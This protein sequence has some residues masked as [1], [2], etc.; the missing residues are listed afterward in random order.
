MN[1]KIGTNHWGERHRLVPVLD[2]QRE[3]LDSSRIQ[4]LISRCFFIQ[5]NSGRC[6]DAATF[7]K[8]TQV[9][10]LRQV[11]RTTY[12]VIITHTAGVTCLAYEVCKPI[13]CIPY[14]NVDKQSAYIIYVGKN[15]WKKN[16]SCC[17]LLWLSPRE[18]RMGTSK[19]RRFTNQQAFGRK[20]RMQHEVMV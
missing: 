5:S 16:F 15:R 17:V 4:R 19:R 14:V 2:A 20:S 9:M 18:C 12:E 13:L 8:L 1:V 11:P 6:I 7:P 10:Q 3:T